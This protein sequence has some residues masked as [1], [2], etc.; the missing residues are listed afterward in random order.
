MT[1]ITYNFESLKKSLMDLPLNNEEIRELYY[2]LITETSKVQFRVTQI[3]KLSDNG[4]PHI[5]YKIFGASAILKRSTNDFEILSSSMTLAICK[6][7]KTE[8]GKSLAPGKNLILRVSQNDTDNIRAIET[9]FK[10]PYEKEQ[11]RIKQEKDAEIA[12]MPTFLCFNSGLEWG[13][14]AINY[15]NRVVKV[16]GMTEKEKLRYS[17]VHK[18]K[19][20][21]QEYL[22]ND[23]PTLAT[24]GITDR[25]KF[26]E[27]TNSYD[28]FLISEEEAQQLKTL[29]NEKQ[30]E[31][32]LIEAEKKAKIEAKKQEAEKIKAD[33]FAEAKATG[34]AV[35]LYSMFV[36]GDD[37]P[38]KYQHIEDNDMGS[39]C[40][41]AMP[42]GS[43]TEDFNPAY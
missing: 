7:I 22:M 32:R 1:N 13:D 40:I 25:Q 3:L 33:K 37:V 23:S 38:R 6:N 5:N 14:Y 42:D 9:Q 19:Y 4:Y 36:S 20:I 43:T 34:K 35:L 12:K 16:R 29:W 26:G 17:D 18:D 8:T 39:I 21:I 10:R 2:E 31:K 15:V 41:Y 24:I 27:C 28:L 30:E 11:D